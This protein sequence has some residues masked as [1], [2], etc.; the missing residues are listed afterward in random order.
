MTVRPSRIAASVIA[1]DRSILLAIQG[2]RDYQPRN[3]AYSLATVQQHESNLTHAEQA[4]IQAEAALEQARSQLI[5]LAH[6]FHSSMLGVKD[7]V[8][9]QFG[10]DSPAMAMIGLTRKSDRKRPKRRKMAA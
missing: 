3:S 1:N 10:V 5:E 4:L 8:T 2:M 6:I 9:T 7:E